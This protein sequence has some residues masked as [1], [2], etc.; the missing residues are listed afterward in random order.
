MK[1]RGPMGMCF[2]RKVLIGWGA[3]AVIVLIAAPQAF[4]AALPVLFLLACPLSMVLMMRGMRGNKGSEVRE[5][6]ACRS[7]GSS[8]STTSE[9]QSGEITRLRADVDQLRAGL[10]E[11]Q[12]QHTSGAE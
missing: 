8:S 10:R 6:N 11:R 9:D 2:N 7:P 5:G 4:L 1:G 3:V 12:A